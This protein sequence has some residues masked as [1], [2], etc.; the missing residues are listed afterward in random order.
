MSWC[1]KMRKSCRRVYSSSRHCLKSGVYQNIHMFYID[2]NLHTFSWDK[3]KNMSFQSRQP[4][5]EKERQWT[6]FLC[7]VN[8]LV[9]WW[10][11]SGNSTKNRNK[12]TKHWKE[13]LKYMH[14]RFF[15]TCVN[16]DMVTWISNT[17]QWFTTHAGDLRHHRFSL[18][19]KKWF[20][21]LWVNWRLLIVQKEAEQSPWYQLWFV[22]QLNA[23][24]NKK[25]WTHHSRAGVHATECQIVSPPSPGVWTG[26]YSQ[27]ETKKHSK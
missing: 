24:V 22:S 18:G 2:K 11:C 15:L 9:H 5:H 8:Y 12:K 25:D 19:P 3:S 23:K 27:A 7:S 4:E 6:G 16:W 10:S 1:D 26:L 14:D 13:T 20:W 17:K 21:D